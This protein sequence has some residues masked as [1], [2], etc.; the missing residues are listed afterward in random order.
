M[1]TPCVQSIGE[2]GL[3][4]STDENT[5]GQA[6]DLVIAR[7][8]QA[9]GDGRLDDAERDF[10]A[11]LDLDGINSVALN[12]LAVLLHHRGDHE[13]AE[14]YLLRSAVLGRDPSDALVNLAAIAQAQQNYAEATAYLQVALEKYGQTPVIMEQMAVLSEAMGDGET[15]ARLRAQALALLPTEPVEG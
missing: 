15:A 5:G 11:A 13:G 4:M 14:L 3:A 6:V 12:N 8:E 9:F 2:M 7:G 10:R 1:V